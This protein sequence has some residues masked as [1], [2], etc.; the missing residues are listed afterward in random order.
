VAADRAELIIEHDSGVERFD[1]ID[2]AVGVAI[3]ERYAI[4]GDD[5]L[6]AK[7]SL[8]WSITRQ[9]EDWR[10]RI[11][12]QME[13]TSNDRNFL[14]RQSLR[15]FEGELSVYSQEW[16]REIRRDLV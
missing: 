4:T 3:A 13:L 10:I 8:R 2:L 9:R 14:L 5:P 12:A 11:E 6:S 7:S 15:A 16:Q 1:A